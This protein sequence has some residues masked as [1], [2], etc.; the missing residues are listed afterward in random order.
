MGKQVAILQKKILCKTF[1]FFKPALEEIICFDQW[2]KSAGNNF[3]AEYI[4]FD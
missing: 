4:Y 3:E 2:E 1:K